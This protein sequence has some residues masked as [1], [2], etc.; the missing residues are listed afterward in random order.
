[1]ASP[2]KSTRRPREPET[3]GTKLGNKL[4]AECNLLTAEQRV[5]ARA[6]A[7]RLIYGA[8]EVDEGAVHTRRR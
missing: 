6:R 5:A 7:M 3:I 1:M 4:R 2:S 8:A